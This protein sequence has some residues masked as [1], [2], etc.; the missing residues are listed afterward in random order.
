[1]DHQSSCSYRCKLQYLQY[2]AVM[3]SVHGT[4]NTDTL[5]ILLDSGIRI[6]SIMVSFLARWTHLPLNAKPNRCPSKQTSSV[7]QQTT[8]NPPIAKVTSLP[9]ILR[10]GSAVPKNKMAQI[11]LH[12]AADKT[13][14][15][16]QIRN[17]ARGTLRS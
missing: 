13:R 8:P 2:L 11:R 16:S 5:K 15:P 6:S 1:M 10:M 4:G 9:D 7:V 14:R 3:E 17:H 12:L